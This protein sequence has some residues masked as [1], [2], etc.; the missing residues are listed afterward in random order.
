MSSLLLIVVYDV[1]HGSSCFIQTPDD[2]NIV[3]DLGVG[4]YK[5]SDDTFSPLAHLWNKYRVRHLD[6]VI[7]THP[8]RDHLDDID[9]FDAFSPRVLHTPRHLSDNEIRVANKPSES[10]IIEQFLKIRARYSHPVAADQELVS[11]ANAGGVEFQFF[12]PFSCGRG[13]LNNHSLVT[14]VSYANSK[15]IIPGD[16]EAASW[17]E[18]LERPAFVRAIR[19]CDILIAP[20]HGREAGYCANLFQHIRPKLTIVSD[21]PGSETS[22]VS[23]Y[24]QQ[25]TGWDVFSRSSGAESRRY[26]VTTASDETI[27]LKFGW[28]DTSRAQPYLNVTIA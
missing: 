15:L 10:A 11:A 16:N 18:L 19:G 5:R 1:E 2:K 12:Q 23:K 22:A 8:H 21:G 24:C 9:N 4:S 28:V 6:Y 25:S 7:V 14:I 17:N 26:C 13:N 27:V 20:H 3:V